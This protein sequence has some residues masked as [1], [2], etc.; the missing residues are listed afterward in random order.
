MN[1]ENTVI[2]QDARIEE[3]QKRVNELVTENAELK[4]TIQDAIDAAHH[5]GHDYVLTG[6]DAMLKI[7]EG[8]HAS[9]R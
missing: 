5:W 6:Y 9:T 8:I 3:L 4:K 1:S 2:M 7:L